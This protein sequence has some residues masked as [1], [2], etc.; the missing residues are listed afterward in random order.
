MPDL[1]RLLLVG[2]I[3]DE[4]DVV[5][6]SI[7]RDADGSYLVDAD[8]SV[9]DVMEELGFDDPEQDEELVNT[10]MGAWVYEQF[11]TIP[12]IGDGFDYHGLRVSIHSMK[13]NRIVKLRVSLPES[14]HREEAEA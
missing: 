2:E 10:L 8:E 11:P 9:S 12:R 1:L 3:W 5:R 4:D 6:E 7:V 13:Q 14:A